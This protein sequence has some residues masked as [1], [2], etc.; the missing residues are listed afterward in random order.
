MM[1]HHAIETNDGALVAG[2]EPEGQVNVLTTVLE[3]F[4]KPTEIQ[5]GGPAHETAGRR[6]RKDFPR[7]A[8]KPGQSMH[9]RNPA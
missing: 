1:T 4:V 9:V 6:D 2:A 8:G 7:A 5:K 3:G